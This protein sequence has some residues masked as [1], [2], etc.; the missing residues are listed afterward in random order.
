MAKYAYIQHKHQY[1]H[2]EKKKSAVILLWA[3]RW[4][5][6]QQETVIEMKTWMNVIKQRHFYNFSHLVSVSSRSLLVHPS[7][8]H[9]MPCS[10]VQLIKEFN[11]KVSPMN[12]YLF[13]RIINTESI[14]IICFFKLNFVRLFEYCSCCCCF[15]CC[16]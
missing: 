11:A 1:T 14:W 10:F 7:T 15:R 2:G 6:K 9:I 12:L 5:L 8:H 3:I 16:S 13:Y 4:V